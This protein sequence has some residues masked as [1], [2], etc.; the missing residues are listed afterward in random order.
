MENVKG[1]CAPPGSAGGAAGGG[2]AGRERA[3]QVMAILEHMRNAGA[4]ALAGEIEQGARQLAA[5]TMD[6]EAF[7]VQFN[8]CVLQFQTGAWTRVG[9][10]RQAEAPRKRAP[11]RKAETSAP[12]SLAPAPPPLAPQAREAGAHDAWA[13]TIT[14]D[15]W[16]AKFAHLAPDVRQL[17][18]DATTRYM[19]ELVQTRLI[20]PFMRMQRQSPGNVEPFYRQLASA[21][22]AAAAAVA[23]PR[24]A[25]PIHVQTAVDAANRAAE[26]MSKMSQARGAPKGYS[27]LVKRA[28]EARE[29]YQQNKRIKS[30]GLSFALP[31]MAPYMT[32]A[33]RTRVQMGLF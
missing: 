16:N 18:E 33:A 27:M 4:H 1:S 3:R 23:G 28:A 9:V 17:L 21:E 6:R 15:A 32:A 12:V 2:E 24:P 25:A 29:R 30:I 8:S 13:F 10:T 19:T 20:E 26:A 11:K 5:G 7:R 22:E 31:Y 14:H